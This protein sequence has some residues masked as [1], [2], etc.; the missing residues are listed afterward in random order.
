MEIEQESQ[1]EVSPQLERSRQKTREAW[2]EMDAEFGLLTIGEVAGL[3]GVNLAKVKELRDADTLIAVNHE[4][5]YL[6]PGFQFLEG[7]VN[8]VMPDLIAE[9]KDSGRT[10]SGLA[11]WMFIPT[12][13]L[14]GKR[15]VDILDEPDKLLLTARSSFNVEW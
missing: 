12:G 11:L 1:P 13:Y 10:E 8:P 9:A 14:D 6:Y 5:E 7:K 2:A 4:D 15:P 3:L